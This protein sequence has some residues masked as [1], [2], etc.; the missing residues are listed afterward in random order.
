ML[1][2]FFVH[3]PVADDHTRFGHEAL[4]QAADRKNRFDAVV[5]EIDLAAAL[6]L[7]PDRAADHLLIELQHVGLNRQAILGWRLDDRHVTDADERHIEGPRNRRR[8]HREYVDFLPELLDLL[9]VRDAEPL[10]LVHHEEA[11][12][13]ELDIFREQPVRAHDDVH[14][15]GGEIRERLL[16]LGFAPESAD[17]LDADREAGEAL[18]QRFLVLKREHRRRREKRHLFAVHYRLE[19]GA[20]GHFGLAVADVAAQQA[21]HRR[22]GLHVVLD[23]GDGRLLIGR[24]LVLERVFELFLPMRVGTERVAGHSFARGVELE[25][26]LGHVAHGLLHPGFRA[27]P[28]RAAEAIDRRPRRTGVFLNEVEPL[29]RNEEFVVAGVSQLEEFLDVVAPD[30]DLLQADEHADAVVDV[31][32][33]VA[34]LEI[35]QI[36]QKCLRRRPPAFGR[37]ALFFEDVVLGVDLQARGGQPEP[38]RQTADRHQHSG[39]ARVFRALDGNREDAVLLQQFDRALGAPRRRRDKQRR[40]AFI[41]APADLGDPVGNAAVEF[42]RRLTRNVTDLGIRGS[43]FGIRDTGPGTRDIR[44]PNPKSQILSI[45]QPEL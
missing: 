32:D 17:H 6:Q 22:R 42:D 23:V 9:F 35:A 36:G 20:H 37:A 28:R 10:F 39:V 19:G 8:A 33:E 40:R 38:T 29:D 18:A 4:N 1:E 16:L 45:L 12:I 7:V 2:R 24:Q 31:D 26:L 41:A 15:A 21:V 43:G 13:A 11:E 5:N 14:F 27:L 30:A 3:L 34:N 25:Q 44:I